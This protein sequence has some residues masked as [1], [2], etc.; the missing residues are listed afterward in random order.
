MSYSSFLALLQLLIFARRYG[1]QFPAAALHIS[2]HLQPNHAQAP[3]ARRAPSKR[4]CARSLMPRLARNQELVVSPPCEE[5]LYSH[6]VV[7]LRFGTA[8]CSSRVLV[9]LLVVV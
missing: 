9:E 5:R 2:L 8:L 4:L 6:V 7:A 3:S 1:V